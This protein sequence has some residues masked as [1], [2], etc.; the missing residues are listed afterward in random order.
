VYGDD[1]IV[2][3][4]S[5]DMVSW[6][7]E[8]F[9][10]QV[11]PEKSFSTGPFRESCGTDAFAGTNV[12]PI[13]V[14]RP[15]SLRADDV[16]AW[17]YSLAN[18]S[19]HRLLSDRAATCHDIWP[20]IHFV[21]AELSSFGPIFVVPDYYPDDSGLRLYGDL[22][23]YISISLVHPVYLDRHGLASFACLQFQY[24]QQIRTDAFLEY[25]RRLRHRIDE[26]DWWGY[27]SHTG[28]FKLFRVPYNETHGTSFAQS[29]LLP[30]N[31]GHNLFSFIRRLG[32]YVIVEGRG[33][34]D[35]TGEDFADVSQLMN[36]DPDVLDTRL[37]QDAL[38]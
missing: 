12:R 30:L 16:R 31:R 28:Q 14:D 26:Q 38:I 24:D 5:Y 7:L 8:C 35:I 21:C 22:Y 34:F 19:L 36:P 9:G 18:L 29:T 6:A 10:F 23:Q 17:M 13:F 11:N 15:R 2:P 32:S 25:H 37:R 3:S 27:C 33:F 1:I 20:F 4:E